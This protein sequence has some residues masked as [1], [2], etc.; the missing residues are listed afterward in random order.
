MVF[1]FEVIFIFVVV[2]IFGVKIIF[3]FVFSFGVVLGHLYFF[4][5]NAKICHNIKIFW[6]DCFVKIMIDITKHMIKMEWAKES[7]CNLSPNLCSLLP[8]L[9]IFVLAHSSLEWVS[10]FFFQRLVARPSYR[11]NRINDHVCQ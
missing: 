8:L 2:F 10:L 9:K 3:R 4:R 1:A 6:L 11:F 5:S 7:L